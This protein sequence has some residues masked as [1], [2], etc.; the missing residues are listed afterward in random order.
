M[1]FYISPP[2]RNP[3]SSILAGVVGALLL[4]GTFMLGFVV[5]LVVAGLGLLLWLGVLLRIKCAQYQMRRQGIDPSVMPGPSQGKGH[6]NDDSLE[7][8]YTVISKER[9][10]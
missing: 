8:E 4:V 6:A 1:P 2:P 9:E 7:A 10:D 3:L 5:L